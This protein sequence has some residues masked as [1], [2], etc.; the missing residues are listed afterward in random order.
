[1]QLFEVSESGLAFGGK[2]GV[3]GFGAGFSPKANTVLESVN[4]SIR[5]NA[6]RHL[7]LRVVFMGN[8]LVN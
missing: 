6:R 7:G 5:I 8:G 4:M 2:G 3:G 1:M